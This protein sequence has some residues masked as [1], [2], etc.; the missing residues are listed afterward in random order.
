MTLTVLPKPSNVVYP[1]RKTHW[2]IREH[3]HSHFT[4]G[5]MRPKDE[6]GQRCLS[7]STLCS[8]CLSGSVELGKPCQKGT[9][10]RRVTARADISIGTRVPWLKIC[11]QAT[12]TQLY[13]PVHRGA[14]KTPIPNFNETKQH[15]REQKAKEKEGATVPQGKDMDAPGERGG[16]SPF[17]LGLLLHFL[18]LLNKALEPSS[19]PHSCL[20]ECQKSHREL[21]PPEHP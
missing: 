5:E 21:S 15:L 7:G 3:Y 13:I 20:R 17:P 18:S 6:M 4:D 2:E 14:I 8:T 19:R 12:E 11:H 16:C 1:Y 10:G 9:G